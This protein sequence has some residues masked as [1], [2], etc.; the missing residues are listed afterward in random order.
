MPVRS[1]KDVRRSTRDPVRAERVRKRVEGELLEMNLGELR[2]ELGVTQAEMADAAEM[3]Q[4]ELSRLERRDDHLVSTLRRCVRALGG[5]LEV[6]A[7]VG[8]KRVR[9]S[10]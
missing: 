7:V 3:T 5:E 9:L 2:R 10:V 4:G 1:W 8:K 6:T